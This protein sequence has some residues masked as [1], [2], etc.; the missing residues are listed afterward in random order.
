LIECLILDDEIDFDL[1]ENEKYFK[2]YLKYYK[3]TF[4]ADVNDFV[5]YYIDNKEALKSLKQSAEESTGIENI[6]EPLEFITFLF[7]IFY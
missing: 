2:D 3:Q 1:K 5:D 6:E 4:K 7:N